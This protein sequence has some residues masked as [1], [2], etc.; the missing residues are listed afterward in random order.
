[1]ADPPKTIL[2]IEDDPET[3]LLLTED[4]TE[5]GYA[6]RVALDG[7]SGLAAASR[8]DPDLILCDVGMRGLTGIDVLQRMN[9]CSPRLRSVPFVFLTA[10]SDRETELHCRR[11]GADDFVSKPIDFEILATIVAA[12]LSGIA[13]SD[14]LASQVSLSERETET[15]T[16]S[17][18]GKTSTEI[19]AILGL[20]KRTVDFHIENACRKLNVATR[21]EA[22]V[23]AVSGRLIR[24]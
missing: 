14:A 13:R 5:R 6:V 7:E 19:A 1:M 15:L 22:A 12:R 21:I 23:K 4:L 2:C 8:H 24:P 18:R 20:A 16:W 9:S 17:A 3:A 10:L 11:L